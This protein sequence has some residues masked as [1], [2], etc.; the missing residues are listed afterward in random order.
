MEQA[1]RRGAS[2]PID[3]P[4]AAGNAA[5]GQWTWDKIQKL[6]RQGI[7]AL[8]QSVKDEFNLG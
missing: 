7:A 3:E 5:P 6:N 4:D 1:R 8:P 2:D